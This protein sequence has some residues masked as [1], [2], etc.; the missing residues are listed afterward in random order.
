GRGRRLVF[1]T[2]GL[3]WLCRAQATSESLR[4]LSVAHSFGER[5][6]RVAR[7]SSVP[8]RSGSG[9]LQTAMDS[10]SPGP[11]IH[12]QW[13]RFLWMGDSFCR[14]EN[15]TR[16]GQ[17]RVAV[18]VRRNRGSAVAAVE[19]ALRRHQYPRTSRI[20][21]RPTLRMLSCL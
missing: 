3:S 1:A 14:R 13:A 4:R 21:P 16:H 20:L 12:S 7:R 6:S 15:R 18:V 5:S 9:V 11:A 2:S 8:L 17:R 19:L 10:E